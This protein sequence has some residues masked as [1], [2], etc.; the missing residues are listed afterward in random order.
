[1]GYVSKD[2]LQR[3][4]QVDVL[5]YVLRCEANNMKRI[6][7]GYR[8]IDHPSIEIKQ[9]GWRWYSRGLHGRTALDY[10]TDVRGYRLA[11][12]VCL[13][14]CEWPRGNDRFDNRLNIPQKQSTDTKPEPLAIPSNI[15]QSEQ[16]KKTPPAP[17]PFIIPRHYKN[18]NR[19]IAYLQSRGIEREL[20]LDCIRRKDLYES[21]SHDC[22][23]IG[24]DDNGKTRYAAIRST[25]SSFKGDVQCSDKRY[26]FL[27]PADNQSSNAVAVYESAI[28]LLSHQ[29]MCLLGYLPPYYGWRL[30]LGGTSLLGLEYFLK[31]HSQVNHCII[32]TDNDEAG[33]LAARKI[34][35]LPGITSQR[36]PPIQGKDWNA[37]LQAV[38]R[39][40]RSEKQ[41]MRICVQNDL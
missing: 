5:D 32:S 13:L 7:N 24:R 1:M 38:Q 29:T 6:G 35:E 9:G 12:A 37:Y 11:D 16:H 36:S 17:P 28:D 41:A 26:S 30:S 15:S 8:M 14:L 20:I 31:S 34:S 3:A 23:F 22:V 21:V 4:R 10:L 2:Q 27:I 19:V 40:E 39:A 33:E 25:T 18:N